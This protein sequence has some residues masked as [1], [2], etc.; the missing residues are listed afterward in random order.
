MEIFG[1]TPVAAI[2]SHSAVTPLR[3][4]LV[5]VVAFVA[6]GFT[7]A[8]AQP[9][10]SRLGPGY[11]IEMSRMIPMRDGVTLEAWIFKPSQLKIKAPAV[12]ELTQYGI[13]GGRHQDFITFIQRGYV[14]VQVEVRGRGRSG[15][16]K[17]DT[18]GL[19]VGRDGYDAVEWIASQPWSDRHVFMYGG[20]FVGL[21]QWRTAAQIPPHLSGIAPYVPIYPGWDVPNTNG[22]PQAWTA[23]ILGYTAG[24][25]LNT[26]FIAGNYWQKKM[27]EHYAQQRSFRTLDESIGIAPDDWW[28]V[29]SRGKKLSLMKMWLDHVGDEAFNLAAEPK[30]TDF[31]KMDFPILT[32]TGFFDDDQPGTL[33]YYSRYSE[34][35][36]A[37]E[38]SDLL[39]IIGPWDHLGTQ[40]PD[41]TIEGLPIPVNA[42]LDM[43]KLQ[44]DWYDWALG[45]GPRPELLRDRVTYYMMGA[46]EWRYA[47]SLEGASSG[48]NLSLFLSDP[49]GKPK[50]Q[51]GPGVLSTSQPGAEP[52]VII[53][54]DP[55]TLPELAVASELA[56]ENLLSQFRAKEKD[57]LVFQSAPLERDTEVAGHMHLNLI[58]QSDA[59]DF[60]LWAQVQMV[61]ADGSAVTLGQDIRRA[62]FRDSFFKQELLKPDQVVTIPFNFYWL[63]WRIPAGARLRLVLMP[64]NSPNYQKNYNTG[65][66]IGYEDPKDARVAH[67]KLFHDGSRSSVLWLPLAADNR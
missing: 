33:H 44:A 54:S 29:D 53:V 36:S 2:L 60:D 15:G 42:V 4:A 14:F 35:A 66:R 49:R 34:Y 43:N 10:A 50:N 17:S 9:S 24:R 47:H 28:M 58:V 52:P 32:A 37:K 45:R 26:E 23:V 39:L 67:I 30:P 46:N 3:A 12:L 19:Q 1:I 20:S 11:D 38:V 62:R 25:T 18:L 13:D 8:A 48:K 56:E 64:L 57:A 61:K 51:S 16:E 59:P 7:L 63:A 41:K 31:A 5:L 65:G 40:H 21:T 55:R 22:I 6:A 27:L